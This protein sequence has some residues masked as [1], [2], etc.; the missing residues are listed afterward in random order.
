MSVAAGRVFIAGGT[1]ELKPIEKLKYKITTEC[2]R[3]FGLLKPLLIQMLQPI[4]Q[5]TAPVNNV[6]KKT[7]P[8]EHMCNKMKVADADYKNL[9]R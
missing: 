6:S 3:E 4:L 9:V 7:T 8:K 5:R 1:P 2:A